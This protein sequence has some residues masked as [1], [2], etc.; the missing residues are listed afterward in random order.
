[1]KLIKRKISIRT[2]VIL[3]LCALLIGLSVLLTV[4]TWVKYATAP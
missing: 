4:S 1:M 3:L 2:A